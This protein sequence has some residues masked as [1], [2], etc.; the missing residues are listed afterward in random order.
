MFKEAVRN[1]KLF[2]L[3]PR[4][5]ARNIVSPNVPK[6]QVIT[7]PSSS[8][9]RNNWGLKFPV[10]D[11]KSKNLEF[12]EFEDELRTNGTA[13]YVRFTRKV[14]NLEHLGIHIQFPRG[15]RLGGIHSVPAS[16]NKHN[17]TNISEK[18]LKNALKKARQGN[19]AE[20]RSIL[21]R[22][23]ISDNQAANIEVSAVGATYAPPATFVNSRDGILSQRSAP[24]RPL[25]K[26]MQR[27]AVAYGGFIAS[28]A[29]LF[30]YRVPS[31]LHISV[32]WQRTVNYLPT[33]SGTRSGEVAV[34][35]QQC[36]ARQPVNIGSLLDRSANV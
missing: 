16:E 9:S 15:R 32:P 11:A 12:K 3:P 29:H 30:G 23:T 1:S 31:E 5:V 20:A 4:S 14:A 6:Y 7:A 18:E 2:S 22:S 34:T 24:G 33:V 36:H 19:T 27:G 26:I 35:V 10:S 25:G 21:Q 17:L 13:S 28:D 8:A